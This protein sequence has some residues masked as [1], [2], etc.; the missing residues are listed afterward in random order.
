[1]HP[2][3]Y[4]ELLRQAEVIENDKK[5]KEMK[6]KELVSKL[7]KYPKDSEVKLTFNL[8]KN[9]LVETCY[10]IGSWNEYK[11]SCS[12][13]T[14]WRRSTI[15]SEYVDLEE[16]ISLLKKKNLN[17]I[18][19]DDMSN[20]SLSIQESSDGSVDVDEIEWTEET[21][22]EEELEDLEKNDLYWDSEITDSEIEFPKGTIWYMDITVNGETFNIDTQ[23]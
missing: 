9:C 19:S 6:N 13:Y 10:H 5:N 12:S 23:D 16:L 7:K 20:I 4:N 2:R 17:E 22:T 3:H 21:P 8:E 1:M 11:F 18:S 15:E 14:N